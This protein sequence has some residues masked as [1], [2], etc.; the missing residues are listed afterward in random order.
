MKDC[1]KPRDTKNQQKLGDVKFSPKP[2]G[3]MQS[4][5]AEPKI[6]FFKK[7]PRAHGGSL[8]LNMRR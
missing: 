7:V 3:E 8:A 6:E 4:F 2:S 1:Y 5:N